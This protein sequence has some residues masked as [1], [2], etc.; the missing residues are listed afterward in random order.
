MKELVDEL[1]LQQAARSKQLTSANLWSFAHTKRVTCV[2]SFSENSSIR[3]CQSREVA[4]HSKI[5]H[6]TRRCRQSKENVMVPWER[7][8][9]SKRRRATVSTRGPLDNV[10]NRNIQ[11]FGAEND[12]RLDTWV[13]VLSV[14]QTIES[15]KLRSAGRERC[16]HCVT[17]SRSADTH[18]TSPCKAHARIS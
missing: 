9:G 7:E 11:T 8:T 4:F 10:N 3:R 13:N 16:L 6:S 15:C 2:C 18:T 17:V 12:L 5:L 14:S 1:P